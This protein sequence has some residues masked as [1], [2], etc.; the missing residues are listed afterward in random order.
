MKQNSQWL[1][2]V[3][4]R[5]K[6]EDDSRIPSGSPTAFSIVSVRSP[7]DA[8][9]VISSSASSISCW[10]SMTSEGTIPFTEISS[11]PTDRPAVSAGLRLT[12]S[13]TVGLDIGTTAVSYTHLR[14]HE[15]DSY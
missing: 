10:Y 5:S 7:V 8:L 13:I 11:S 1:S 14:A 15:T 12:I 6:I 3:W 9:T 4:T 2:H